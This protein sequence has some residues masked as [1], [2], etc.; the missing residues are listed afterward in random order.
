MKRDSYLK[1]NQQNNQTSN[2]LFGSC[3]QLHGTPCLGT[4][5]ILS[6]EEVRQ[7]AEWRIHLRDFYE[8]E[9][10]HSCDAQQNTSVEDV[11]CMTP[12]KPAST[13]NGFTVVPLG[14]VHTTA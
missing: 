2:K 13:P 10:G 5:E 3:L 1:K 6:D 14:R 8:R 9:V 12:T 11:P 7:L 4:V